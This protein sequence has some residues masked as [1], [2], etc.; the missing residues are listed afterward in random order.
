MNGAKRESGTRPEGFIGGANPKGLYH[1][2]NKLRCRNT[3]C[4]G[5]VM[6]YIVSGA[7]VLAGLSSRLVTGITLRRSSSCQSANLFL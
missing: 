2:G 5:I 6:W 4:D 3:I 1:S 7:K